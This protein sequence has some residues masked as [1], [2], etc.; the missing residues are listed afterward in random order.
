MER[1]LCDWAGHA[2]K[3]SGV[4]DSKVYFVTEID[5]KHELKSTFWYDHIFRMQK[6][7]FKQLDRKQNAKL[8]AF[9]F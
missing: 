5:P 6:L 2:T 3:A 9:I 1:D 8:Y 4:V 7:N